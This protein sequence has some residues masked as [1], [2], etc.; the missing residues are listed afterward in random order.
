MHTAERFWSGWTPAGWNI[1][2]A[3]KRRYRCAGRDASIPYPGFGKRSFPRAQT[4]ATQPPGIIGTRCPSCR[5][6]PILLPCP[7]TLSNVVSRERQALG[8][9]SY[10]TAAAT[11]EGKDERNCTSC[12]RFSHPPG[13]SAIIDGKEGRPSSTLSSTLSGNLPLRDKSLLWWHDDK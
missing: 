10:Q 13:N 2:I 8:E 11:S 12:L 4:N 3:I 1:K 6:F 9:V 5:F 7:I